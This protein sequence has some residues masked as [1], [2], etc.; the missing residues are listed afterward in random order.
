MGKKSAAKKDKAV[1]KPAKKKSSGKNQGHEFRCLPK[2]VAQIFI[3]LKDHPD[4]RA[5]VDEMGFSAISY[6]SNEYLNQRLLKQIYDRYDIYDNTI[7]SDAAAVNITTEKIGHALGLSSKGTPYD[8]KV[9]KK[10]LSQEDSDVHKF[11]QGITIVAL[12]N[13]IKTTPID[14]DENKKL[15]MWSFMLFVQ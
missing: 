9:D 12:Q 7:Y 15:W 14:T 10:K 11:F 3:Y 8:I 4:K 6:L 1:A 5:L 2:T 13:L